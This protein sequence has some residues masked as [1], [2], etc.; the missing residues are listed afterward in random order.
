MND[1]L[2]TEE[3]E[4]AFDIT[5]IKEELDKVWVLLKRMMDY[6]KH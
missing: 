2:E 4:K 3:I 6:L 1:I 5:T